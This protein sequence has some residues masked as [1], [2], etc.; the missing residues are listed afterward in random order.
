MSDA[1]LCDVLIIWKKTRVVSKVAGTRLHLSAGYHSAK[2]LANTWRARIVGDTFEVVIVRAEV[3]KEGS[4]V[5]STA[6]RG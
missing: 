5:P 1:Y 2:Q 3:Y 4:S 6:I